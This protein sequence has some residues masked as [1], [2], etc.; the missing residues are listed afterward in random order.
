MLF[1]LPSLPY[2]HDALK[3]YISSETIEYHYEKHH[4]GYVD[5]LNK[6]LETRPEE[7][8]KSLEDLINTSSGALFNNA[9]Q[10]WNHNFYWKCLTP[11]GKKTPEK[12][13]AKMID[14][15]FGSF[16][17]FKV[18]FKEQALSNFGSGWTWLVKKKDGSIAIVN[19][20]NAQNPMT[21]KDKPLLTLD[22]WE[23]A[24]YID[25]RNDRSLYIDNFWKI[26]NWD[27]VESQY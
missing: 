21:G 25:Y 4:R 27:F 17:E 11:K 10:V 26:V 8:N 16:E 12:K 14:L 7:K 9:A 23:H 5:K 1:D 3:P 2:Q 13:M 15:T 24:Y 18:K 22:V 20:S 19:T 6:L